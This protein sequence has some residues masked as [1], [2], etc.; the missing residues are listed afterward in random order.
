MA[1]GDDVAARLWA[2]DPTLWKADDPHHQH[3]IPGALGWLTVF[4][5]VRDQMEGLY[6]FLGELRA[7]GYRH[8]V[9]LGMGGSSLAPEV[10]TK[11]LEGERGCLELR[12]LDS[13]DPAAVTAVE[14]DLD[15]ERTLFVVASKS[16]GTTETAS[17]HAHFYELMR[18]LD[19]DHAGHHFAAI[20]DED[21]ALQRQALEQDFRAV[22]VNPSDIGGRY[23]ALS[24]FGLVP[25]VLAGLDLEKLLDGARRMAAA[26]AAD[27]PPGKNPAL[28]LGTRLGELALAGRD[29]LTL[30]TPSRLAPLGAWVEQLV[31][32][33]TGKEGLGILPVDLERLGPPEVYGDDRVFVVVGLRGEPV[34]EERL[35]ELAAVGHPVLRHELAEPH[36]IGGEFL[37]WELATAVA[38][39]VLG[40]DPFDQPNV[41]ESKD[42]TKALLQAFAE[43]G[44]L[45]AE[46]GAS[47]VGGGAS[48]VEGVQTEWTGPDGRFAYPVDDEALGAA[49]RDL[50]GR[51]AP[52]DYLALQAFVKPD[53]AV[54]DALQAM[55]VGL[56][57]RLHVATTLGYG[58]RYLHSTGQYHKGGPGRGLF[59]QVIGHD[60][61]DV[62]VPG[63]PY[64]FGVLKRAQARGDL[65]ALRSR[66]KP[67]LRVCLG[68]DVGAGLERLAALVAGA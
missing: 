8:A 67:A 60:P 15:L 55:R 48:P 16:G 50:L 51:A 33:S 20:T 36:E 23:S 7:D 63:Q 52:G 21:T 12:V 65:A 6:Q 49:L 10:M 57:D 27:V 18:Q 35:D 29:K 58:P 34:D 43:R 3:L 54:W 5:D 53:P 14:A 46:T 41:Q 31:A 25:A 2:A 13:T 4:E 59:L 45:P 9:L 66:G 61:H 38:G 26:C 17:F 40:I 32:E 64:S 47:P 28:Q 37:R 39:A 42:N 30:V 22:F 68:D 62:A 44:E 19:G 11:V 1:L 56:R 24:F